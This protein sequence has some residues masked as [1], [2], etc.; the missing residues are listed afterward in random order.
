[1]AEDNVSKAL[2]RLINHDLNLVCSAYRWYDTDPWRVQVS[3]GRKENMGWDENKVFLWE[4]ILTV[5]VPDLEGMDFRLEQVANLR[6]LKQKMIADSQRAIT[7][8]EGR[9]Q[10]LLAIGN[11][12]N[13]DV[14]EG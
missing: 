8:V 14:I 5:R 12:S 11:S 10:N 6:A 9:I 13:P 3:I 2:P 1:M 4:D 7:E